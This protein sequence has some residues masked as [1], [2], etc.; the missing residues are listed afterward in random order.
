MKVDDARALG[1]LLSARIAIANGNAVAD[2]AIK[3]AVVLEERAGE[4]VLCKLGDGIFDGIRGQMRVK[5]KEGV[6]EIAGEDYLA[7]VGA[8]QRPGEAE[9]FLVNGID[10][11]LAELGFQVPGEG[12]LH[13]T[14][15]AVDAGDHRF[16]DTTL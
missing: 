13:Q 3:V 4:I 11:F 16:Y 8:A 7:R 9:A 6:A 2:Q 1:V 14:V 5:A 15:F 10:G 12:G